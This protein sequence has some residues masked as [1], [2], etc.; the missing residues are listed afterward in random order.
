MNKNENIKSGI[1]DQLKGVIVFAALGLIVLVHSIGGIQ[2]SRRSSIRDEIKGF[3]KTADTNSVVR[4]DGIITQNPEIIVS[5]LKTIDERTPHH[6]HPLKP[7][8]ILVETGTNSL[9]L[10][11]A[12]DS[13]DPIEYWVEAPDFSPSHYDSIGGIKTDIFDYK[14]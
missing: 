7:F 4:V 6:S 12:R 8:E 10:V 5:T 14:K 9:R 2:R 1:S 13:R 11:L 3:L